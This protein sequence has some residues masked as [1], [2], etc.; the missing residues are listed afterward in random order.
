VILHI[1]RAWLLDLAHRSLPGDP[2]VL[3]FGFSE[4]TE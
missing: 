4:L 2:D 3:D 1:D